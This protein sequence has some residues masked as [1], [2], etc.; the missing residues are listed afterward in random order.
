MKKNVVLSTG[1]LRWIF[2]GLYCS[3]W[4]YWLED[5]SY[6]LESD[7]EEYVAQAT[8]FMENKFWDMDKILKDIPEHL[9]GELAHQ[10]NLDWIVFDGEVIDVH[11][12]KY[13]NFSTDTFTFN[14]TVN[15]PEMQEYLRDV[16]KRDSSVIEK[17]HENNWKSCS[18]FISY[19]PELDEILELIFKDLSSLTDEEI[20]ILTSLALEMSII[21]DG[22]FEDF[23]VHAWENW[24][25]NTSN[26]EYYK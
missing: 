21:M 6:D 4:S 15:L 17:F 14:V 10:S 9:I 24:I 23:E 11:S 1:V 8:D 7:D 26:Y 16:M 20:S 25:G 18:G 13:Y 2:S 19:M 12:P 3:V 22:E 5:F